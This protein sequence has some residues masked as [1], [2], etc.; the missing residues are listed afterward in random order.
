MII[1]PDV[2]F[3]LAP[4]PDNVVQR[5]ALFGTVALE[6]VPELLALVVTHDRLDL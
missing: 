2:V 4:V 1:C 6:Q 3:S 5:Y